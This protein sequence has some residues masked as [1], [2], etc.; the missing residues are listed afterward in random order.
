MA[1]WLVVALL[2]GYLSFALNVQTMISLLVSQCVLWLV[3]VGAMHIGITAWLKQPRLFGQTFGVSAYALVPLGFA[4]FFGQ[5]VELWVLATTAA[6]IHD[7]TGT[8]IGK[9][10]VIALG[11]T[12]AAYFASRLIQQFAFGFLAPGF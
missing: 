11:G 7:L 8:T 3:R 4:P 1:S 9:A 10:I 5:L 6:A 12:V 2:G